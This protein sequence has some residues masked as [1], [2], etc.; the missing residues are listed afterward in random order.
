VIVLVE[1]WDKNKLD[2]RFK[3]TQ[4]KHVSLL[5]ELS[6]LLTKYEPNQERWSY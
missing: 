3:V 2:Y 6:M 4:W 5:V 1:R